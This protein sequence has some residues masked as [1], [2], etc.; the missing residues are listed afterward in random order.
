MVKQQELAEQ[1]HSAIDEALPKS[2]A[3]APELDLEFTDEARAFTTP[4]LTGVLRMILLTAQAELGSDLRK[5]WV[6]LWT[7]GGEE[8]SESLD[9]I[10]HANASQDRLWEV[11]EIIVAKTTEAKAG[12]SEDELREY[13]RH[14]HFALDTPE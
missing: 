11:W 6:E 2:A 4:F 14:I 5:A 12:W 10:I 3:D 8:N 9:L 1:I 7:M 13:A